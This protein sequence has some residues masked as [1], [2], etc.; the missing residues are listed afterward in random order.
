MCDET[1]PFTEV[2]ERHNYR[3]E[4][5]EAEGGEEA[6]KPSN[7]ANVVMGIGVTFISYGSLGYLMGGGVLEPAPI[8]IGVVILL[9]GAVWRSRIQR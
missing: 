6:M 1:A 2:C 8:G 5:A 9:V 4:G 7:A 3:T